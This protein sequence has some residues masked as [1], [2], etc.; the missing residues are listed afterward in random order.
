MSSGIL[1]RIT[2]S[3]PPPPGMF[4]DGIKEVYLRP[5]YNIKEYSVMW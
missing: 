4:W 5:H 1:M 2:G 3:N